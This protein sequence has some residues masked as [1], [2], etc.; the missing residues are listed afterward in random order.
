MASP[1]PP[2]LAACNIIRLLQS[3]RCDKRRG[4]TVTEWEAPVNRYLNAG[5]THNSGV[6][7]FWNL[8]YNDDFIVQRCQDANSN[9]IFKEIINKYFNIF[10][11]QTLN[12]LTIFFTFPAQATLTVSPSD[13]IKAY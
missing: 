3:Q 5:S 10:L 2:L 9:I 4:I 11:R 6:Y 12:I 7:L 13:S 8:N 1:S